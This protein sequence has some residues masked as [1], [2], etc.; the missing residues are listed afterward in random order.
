MG[1]ELKTVAFAA[2]V[3][4]ICS[5]LLAGVHSAL[6]PEQ[7]ANK[8]LDLQQKVL[9]AFG[10]KVRDHK[11]KLILSRQE[12]D[13]YFREQILAVVLD[14]LGG[15]AKGAN[16]EDLGSEDIDER[17]KKTGRKRYYPLFIF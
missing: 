16:I 5:L 9:T 3:C 17:D 15:I 7:D 14:S 10:V 8:K 12:V 2:G 4:V 13:R 11:G 6:K 1:E